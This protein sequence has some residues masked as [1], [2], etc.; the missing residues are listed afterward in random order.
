M[1]DP[2]PPHHPLP[3][4]PRSGSVLSE[5]YMMTMFTMKDGSIV[6][7][8]ISQ[9]NDDTLVVMTNPFDPAATKTISK[10]DIKSRDLS[11]VSLM[12]PGLLNTLK[13]DE[14]LDLL[15]YLESMGDAQHPDF[16]KQADGE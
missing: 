14:I 10:P 11:K 12:P 9:E 4:A 15:A 3:P 8:R 6:A 13:Q 2:A 16:I 5:Q 7:G 1:N